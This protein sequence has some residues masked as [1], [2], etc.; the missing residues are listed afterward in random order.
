M[1]VSKEWKYSLVLREN[2]K[3]ELKGDAERKKP[4]T[5]EKSVGGFR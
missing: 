3:G 2:L 4:P 1:I 5:L